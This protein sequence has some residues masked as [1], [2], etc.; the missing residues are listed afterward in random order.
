MDKISYDE[1]ALNVESEQK[2]K[3]NNVDAG[4]ILVVQPTRKC[5]SI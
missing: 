3:K 1:D 2:K 4:F 5:A